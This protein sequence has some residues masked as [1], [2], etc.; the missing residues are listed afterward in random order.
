MKDKF[1]WHFHPS[2]N[3]FQQIWKSAL[4]SP[5]SSVLLNLYR[6]PRDVIEYI[7]MIFNQSKDQLWLTNQASSEF[8]KNRHKVI[9]SI[10]NNFKKSMKEMESLK[11][12]IK[13]S[14]Q[15]LH[16][17]RVIPK[18]LINLIEEDGADLIDK[19]LEKI[20]ALVEQYPD[21]SSNDVLTDDLVELFNNK[22]GSGFSEDEKNEFFN[23]G[24]K[25]FA[26]KIPPGYCDFEK[27]EP[28]RY[29]DLILWKE[30][31]WKAKQEKRPVIFITNDKKD[32]WWQKESGKTIGPRP[33]LLKEAFQETGQKVWIYEYDKFFD[34]AVRHFNVEIKD[35]SVEKI[36]EK[37]QEE[38]SSI[39]NE[40]TITCDVCGNQ[41][42]FDEGKGFICIDFNEIWKYKR[43]MDEWEKNH[44]KDDERYVG[45]SYSEL[46]LRPDHVKW[47]AFHYSCNDE[48]G[49]Y[50]SIDV[51]RI[52]NHKEITQWSA[53]LLRKSWLTY[54]N[55]SDFIQ[56]L[57]GN[58]HI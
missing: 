22:T 29:G 11:S 13:S 34:Y 7:L 56:N 35:S 41:I 20:G 44:P 16:H 49:N 24:R 48:E 37:I 52:Q 50:Y 21:F 32:D 38:K 4:I 6:Y 17:L 9:A 42:A 23:E 2:A 53:H 39:I 54:T 58:D 46:M 45:F 8:L 1:P 26:S 5:D 30:I 27:P 43:D 36:K 3:E 12:S 31:L 18:E 14:C 40:L 57:S 55:W 15:N 51:S 25:R 47:N 10:P 19:N 33:E 28:D